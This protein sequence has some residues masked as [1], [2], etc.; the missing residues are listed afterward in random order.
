MPIKP[1]E[2]GWVEFIGGQYPDADD[3]PD[4]E[5]MPRRPIR[6]TASGDQDWD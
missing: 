1:V 2:S 3:G 5:E 4:V 6:V